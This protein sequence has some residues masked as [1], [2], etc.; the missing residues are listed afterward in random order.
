MKAQQQNTTT[1]RTTTHSLR[2]RGGRPIDNSLSITFKQNVHFRRPLSH[3]KFYILNFTF[4][5][6]ACTDTSV[7]QPDAPTLSANERLVELS[8]AGLSAGDAAV[9]KATS[10]S[11]ADVANATLAG[12]T[13]IKRLTILCFV[14]L[15]T[16]GNT[17]NI[18]DD[19][20]LERVY[21][22][23]SGGNINDMTLVADANGYR[24]GIGVPK[25]DTRKRAFLLK[26]NQFNQVNYT[27]ARVTD[28]PRTSAT[29]YSTV[30]AETSSTLQSTD[31]LACPLLMA[32]RAA[33]TVITDAGEFLAEPVFTQA[34]LARGVPA[35][36]IRRVARVDISNPDITGFTITSI[37]G[38][39]NCAVPLFNDNDGGFTTVLSPEIP[40]SNAAEIPAALYLYP[41]PGQAEI[42]LTGTYAGNPMTLKVNNL[43]LRPNTRYTLAVRNDESN[44]RLAITVA[45][46]NEGNDIETGDISA[47]ALNS[48]GEFAAAPNG[49][50]SGTQPGT[51]TIDPTNRIITYST[52]TYLP[53]R[54]LTLRGAA[55]D[56]N[57]VGILF[58]E[59]CWLVPDGQGA[60]NA[61]SN[62]YIQTISVVTDPGSIPDTKLEL[63][64]PRE[65][66]LTLV[67]RGADGQIK[68]TEYTIR[69]ELADIA[70]APAAIVPQLGGLASLGS[71]DVTNRIIHLPPVAGAE[72]IVPDAQ[73]LTGDIR[74]RVMHQFAYTEKEYSWLEYKERPNFIED[75][76]EL[77]SA[78]T[79]QLRALDIPRTAI[80]YYTAENNIGGTPRTGYLTTRALDDSDP[81][82]P[83]D[84]TTRWTIIQDATIDESRLADDVSFKLKVKPERELRVSGDTVYVNY[85]STDQFAF[86][87]YLKY[88]ATP[89]PQLWDRLNHAILPERVITLRGTAND[90]AYATSD[91]DWLRVYHLTGTDG[92]NEI[93]VSPRFYLPTGKNPDGTP[94]HESPRFGTFTVHLRDGKTRTFVV[95]QKVYEIEE[96]I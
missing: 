37:K 55:G 4:L 44:L 89:I 39:S 88:L 58:P 66:V 45:P 48:G 26:A 77:L 8:L 15:K 6:L 1:A 9:Q 53:G 82:N 69:H 30:L 35:R 28:V 70:N 36:M 84:I 33:H 47:S 83:A 7:D 13:A 81:A 93:V 42:T 40:L 24:A 78:G 14:D 17:A 27:A 2:E 94:Y 92:K 60:F 25:D 22:Y 32:A 43:N 61:D 67:T 20:T 65:T 5:L 11:R 41:S 76:E 18:L 74:N 3:F 38:E 85:G 49:R 72:I 68:Y 73:T 16:D 31:K 56:I 52:A 86:D 75:T 23:E 63:Y 79:P 90:L 95:R 21:T 10:V 59:N 87:A 50:L 64:I 57:P 62:R 96:G 54:F 46:W 12:E 34:D 91:K 80:Y 29:T 19:Y 51:Y 71:I